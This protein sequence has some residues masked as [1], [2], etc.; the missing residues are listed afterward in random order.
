MKRKWEYDQ[1]D[2]FK[3]KRKLD[4]T[5]PTEESVLANLARL[6]EGN[7]SGCTAISVYND[8]LFVS[9]NGIHLT[10]KF[11]IGETRKVALIRRVLAYFSR[12]AGANE[13]DEKERKK[14]FQ[15]ICSTR[16]K[17][18]GKGEL[19]L[20]HRIIKKMAFKVLTE[21]KWRNNYAELMNEHSRERK[22]A[23]AKAYELIDSLARDFK[24]VERFLQNNRDSSFGR[25][26]AAGEKEPVTS[27]QHEQ[28]SYSN[29]NLMHDKNNPG[30]AI[31]ALG[32]DVHAELQM[33]DFLI[34][35]R[36]LQTLTNRIQL[37]T[38]KLCCHDCEQIINLCN[39][40]Q[41]N[42][43]KALVTRGSHELKF[44]CGIPIFCKDVQEEKVEKTM[45]GKILQLRKKGCAGYY[46]G[47][48]GPVGFE[49]ISKIAEIAEKHGKEN[50]F[51]FSDKEFYCKL[52]KLEGAMEIL[53]NME[54]KERR[55]NGEEPV[56]QYL[57]SPDTSIE[58][59]SEVIDELLKE[60]E[61]AKLKN[62][63]NPLNQSDNPDYLYKKEDIS[64]IASHLI[65]SLKDEALCFSGLLDKQNVE[66]KLKECPLENGK[67]LFGI[68]LGDG[69]HD[70]VAFCIGSSCLVTKASYADPL[71]SVNMLPFKKAINNVFNV[72]RSDN[73]AD[74]S[75]HIKNQD[76]G[77]LALKNL[78]CWILNP[79]HPAFFEDRGGYE[80][81]L[82]ESRREFAEIYAREVFGSTANEMNILREIWKKL[83]DSLIDSVK[84]ILTKEG[85]A[86]K[87]S[88][89]LAFF[90]ANAK[91]FRQF[92][93]SEEETL[94]DVFLVCHKK[95][96]LKANALVKIQEL[97]GMPEQKKN[98][99]Q[100]VSCELETF[101]SKG[102]E[103]YPF[104]HGFFSNKT[105]Q[106]TLESCKVYDF[107]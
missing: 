25:A 3:R 18:E 59:H 78:K 90:K 75:D 67:K 27:L 98:K 38:S 69:D 79:G 83:P 16:I 72:K 63:Q 61:S 8:K 62:T 71:G 49:D 31:L 15:E 2:K 89:L 19:R 47:S 14:V 60:M 28:I 70:Y 66:S 65:S 91:T 9:D 45:A 42:L 55:K 74:Y 92:R 87:S 105:P 102:I 35:T 44:S 50:V 5:Q 30:Y 12:M 86:D 20:N 96:A 32:F 88:C 52:T 94:L 85:E 104:N 76:Y 36:V 13:L 73:L 7:S 46:V 17:G 41:T 97:A 43:K 24:R 54:I 4:E 34:F 81:H 82:M 107:I 99:I 103:V 48:E 1:E 101:Q 39:Q 84:D 51:V 56:E 53:N 26:L 33:V 80:A 58:D 37:G 77:L 21:K 95:K 64:I 23:V 22:P 106:S 68:Y 10:K 29:Y 93:V 11:T 40:L 6:L 100:E 57:Y